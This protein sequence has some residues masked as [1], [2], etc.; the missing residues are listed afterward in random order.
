MTYQLSERDYMKLESFCKTKEMV[1]RLN[2]HPT[3]SKKIFA[4]YT[5]DKELITTMY[6]EFK[7]LNYMY[8]NGKMK[9][10]ENIPKMGA[11]GRKKKDEGVNSTMIHCKKF[12]KCPN[13]PPVQ[14]K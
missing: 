4:S 8:A 2:R 13:V 7:N 10:V 1:T 12:C 6:W 5:S 9:L 11:G 3:E 14:Q